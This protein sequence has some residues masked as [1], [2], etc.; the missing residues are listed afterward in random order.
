MSQDQKRWLFWNTFACSVCVFVM[1][2]TKWLFRI[3]HG[4]DSLTGRSDVEARKSTEMS[5][6]YIAGG[7]A[8]TWS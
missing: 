7:C 1:G 6:S 2:P 4:A 5:L 8:Q 3:S